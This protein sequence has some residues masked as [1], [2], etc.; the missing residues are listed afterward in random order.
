MCGTDFAPPQGAGTAYV[1]ASRLNVRA[2]PN[3]DAALVSKLAIQTKVNVTACEAAYCNMTVPSDIPDAPPLSGFVPQASLTTSA[4]TYESLLQKALDLLQSAYSRCGGRC[5]DGILETAYALGTDVTLPKESAESM[6]VPEQA[7]ALTWVER[8]CVL[9]P[10]DERCLGA[11]QVNMR[12]TNRWND[13]AVIEQKKTVSPPSADFIMHQGGLSMPKSTL[14]FVDA[15]TDP[16]DVLRA[17][18][19]FRGCT[20]TKSDETARGYVVSLVCN[21]DFSLQLH[22]AKKDRRHCSED[23][24]RERYLRGVGSN[25]VREPFTAVTQSPGAVTTQG[26]RVGDTIAM[27]KA[28]GSVSCERGSDKEASTWFCKVFNENAIYYL[29][30][31]SHSSALDAASAADDDRIQALMWVFPGTLN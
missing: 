17:S 15:H 19:W 2:A 22:G 29:V 21:S 18:R 25:T 16:M 11:L 31:A 28:K 5:R 8:A 12:A 20:K 10:D 3:P 30:S 27:L 6:N 4:F 1:L 14:T 9:K 23:S 13:A 24:P 7:E 26:T